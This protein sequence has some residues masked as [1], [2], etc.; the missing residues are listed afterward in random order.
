MATDHFDLEGTE[1]Y[2][3]TV[4]HPD[5]DFLAFKTAVK[6]LEDGQV[7]IDPKIIKSLRLETPQEVTAIPFY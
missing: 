2:L 6:V 1:D 4:T 3:V 5:Y 7:A